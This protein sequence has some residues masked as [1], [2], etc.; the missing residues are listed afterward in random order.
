[1]Q[2]IGRSKTGQRLF[3][4]IFF[5]LFLCSGL[6]LF[7]DFGLSWDERFHVIRGELY[8]NYLLHRDPAVFQDN[9]QKNFGPL[10]DVLMTLI[11]KASAVDK[12][13]RT[14]Y[15]ARHLL[16][17]LIFFAGTVFLYLLGRRVFGDWRAG[18]L[19]SLFLVLSPRFFAQ[20]FY[21]VKDI[22]LLTAVVIAMY[23]MHRFLE[24]PNL[25]RLA[26][27][28][29]ACA[30]ATDVRIMGG[31][32]AVLTGIALAFFLGKSR[33]EPK[34]L[35][36]FLGYSTGF[37]LIWFFLTVAF[38][39]TLW[40]SPLSSFFKVLTAASAFPWYGKV[41]YLGKFIKDS[42]LPWHYIP[43][44][45]L[46]STPLLYLSLFIPGAGAFFFDVFKKSLVF[47]TRVFSLVILLWFFLPILVIILAHVP[48]HDEYRHIFFIY[49]ALLLMSVKGLVTISAFLK[50]LAG[51]RFLRTREAV[52]AAWL[53]LGLL[54]VGLFMI[55]NHPFEM[56]YFN[57]LAGKD[58]AQVALKFEMD[59]WGLSYRAGL[60]YLLRY[61]PAETIKVRA[62]N[63]PGELNSLIL[64]PEERKRLV[65]VHQDADKPKYFMTNYRLHPQDY[66]L[67]KVYAISVGGAKILGVYRVR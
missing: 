47:L 56:V 42:H 53:V 46:I 39:P 1:M 31:I 33:R 41:F 37:V 10:P 11:T 59:Y 30:I 40:K 66:P 13:S 4:F 36:R 57:R 18:L 24:K 63:F 22:S 58:L 12:D 25:P 65:F 19:G 29:L 62:L 61:D 32:T 28:A 43:V 38:W 45:I 49:P 9:I 7:D 67:E 51:P 27:H 44:W 26:V 5:G 3:V 16:N 52:L 55:K 14:F 50:K 35:L 60:E 8:L 21:N 23:T 64:R 48:T 2:G 6:L 34:D 15:L 54:P 17:F 20:G